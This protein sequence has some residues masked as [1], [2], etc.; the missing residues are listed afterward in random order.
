MSIEIDG[1]ITKLIDFHVHTFPDK[2]AEKAVGKLQKISGLT[3]ITDGTISDTINKMQQFNIDRS[4]ILNIA[5]AP[6]QQES[7]NNCAAKINHDYGDK[8]T[9]FGSVHFENP[10]CLA[11]LERIKS[12]GI[13]G[14]KLHP[15]YQGFM[16]D[17][18]RLYPIY[19]KCAELN[20]P[21]VFHAGYDCY[22]PELVHAM[23]CA[24]RKVIDMFPDLVV[25]LAHFGGLMH[26]DDVEKYLIGQNVYLDT[27]MCRSFS[28]PEQF[29]RMVANHDE[30]K[31][32]F[33]S[34]C[35]W[36]NPLSDAMY[37][38][39]MDLSYAK[40]QKIFSQNAK[41]LLGL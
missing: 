5:T 28:T 31:I 35:P 37:I 2:I 16:I 36:E 1:N 40:K 34:D 33:G 15:D 41:L 18:K 3:P 20:L 21:I 25:I 12:L 11:E 24:S 22:S 19:D 32:L 6:S 17:D 23:P 29:S 38:A 4:V 9:A 10:D 30:N 39:S 27:S 13:K 14:V 7:I 26:W 8:L